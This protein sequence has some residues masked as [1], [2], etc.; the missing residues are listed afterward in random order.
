MLGH[1]LNAARSS[2]LILDK[3]FPPVRQENCIKCLL[4]LSLLT[5]WDSPI[6]KPTF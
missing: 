3:I 4:P 5:V 2:Y 6:P 1:N